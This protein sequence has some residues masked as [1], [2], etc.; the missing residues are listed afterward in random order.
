MLLFIFLLI[1]FMIIV[2]LYAK[3]IVIFF[4][5]FS[6]F[7]WFYVWVGPQIFEWI[8]KHVQYTGGR[9]FK[10]SQNI[11]TIWGLYG[12]LN[13]FVNEHVQR[14]ITLNILYMAMLNS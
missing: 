13:I 12:S 1:L 9:S 5:N 2:Y 11:S 7:Q 10:L 8:K 6:R 3:D 4:H 14:V